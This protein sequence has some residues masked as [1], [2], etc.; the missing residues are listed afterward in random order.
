M[1]PELKDDLK[2]AWYAATLASSLGVAAIGSYAALR[3][4]IESPTPGLSLAA[5]SALAIGGW[6]AVHSMGGRIVDGAPTKSKSEPDLNQRPIRMI[7]RQ[8]GMGLK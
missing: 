4:A 7:P 3:L 2:A 8:C 1:S 6:A 5:A